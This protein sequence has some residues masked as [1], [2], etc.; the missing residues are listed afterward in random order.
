MDTLMGTE[1][2]SKVRNK[3][4]SD[5]EKMMDLFLLSGSAFNIILGPSRTKKGIQIPM[6]TSFTKGAVVLLTTVL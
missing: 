5:W 6:N 4:D 2:N 1:Y 3:S